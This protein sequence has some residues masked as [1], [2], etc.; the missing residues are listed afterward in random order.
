VQDRKSNEQT[1]ILVNTVHIHECICDFAYL[2]IAFCWVTS[3]LMYDA[4][5]K[6]DVDRSIE[7]PI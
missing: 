1:M 3:M 2:C 6:W 4:V 7:G 5:D